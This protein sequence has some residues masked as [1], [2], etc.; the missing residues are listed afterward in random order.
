MNSIKK[1]VFLERL[2]HSLS[3]APDATKKKTFPKIS[4][5]HFL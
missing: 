3:A 2:E 4:K 1:K 5:I